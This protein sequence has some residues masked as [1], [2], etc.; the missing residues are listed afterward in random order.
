[1]KLEVASWDCEISVGWGT[2]PVRVQVYI[3]GERVGH[4][5][6][7]FCDLLLPPKQACSSAEFA[8]FRLPRLLVAHA[9]GGECPLSEA[10]A[11]CRWPQREGWS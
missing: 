8:H 5:A 6:S 3:D 7:Y 1:L 10:L 2:D 11:P 9:Y 4:K